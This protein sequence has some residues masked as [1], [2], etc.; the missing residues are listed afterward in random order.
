MYDVGMPVVSPRNRKGFV[1]GSVLT[2]V[3]CNHIEADNCVLV[4]VTAEKIIAA[5][6]SIIYN[7]VAEGDEQILHVA[8][9]QVS[10]LY[11]VVS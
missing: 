9:G 4:N 6:G 10:E 5:P 11:Y 3:R 8:A 2:G 1:K 7:I